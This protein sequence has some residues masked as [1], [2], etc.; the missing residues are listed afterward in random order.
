MIKY[1]VTVFVFIVTFHWTKCTTAFWFLSCHDTHYF[2][3]TCKFPHHNPVT[4]TSPVFLMTRTLNTM[5][6]GMLVTYYKPI[7]QC[8][9]VGPWV[10]IQYIQ[11]PPTNL[12]RFP[13]HHFVECPLGI[14]WLPQ[15][16][17]NIYCIRHI[18]VVNFIIN[19][20]NYSTYFSNTGARVA[21]NIVSDYRLDGRGSIPGRGK[22]FFL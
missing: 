13:I 22:E 20:N 3:I 7:F 5:F 8:L 6:P 17:E 11:T 15:R 4:G 9:H 18:T 14:T 21:V 10:L 2:H 12:Y 1:P 19:N 16:I